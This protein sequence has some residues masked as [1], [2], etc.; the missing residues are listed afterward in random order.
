[1]VEDHNK[2]V[3]LGEVFDLMTAPTNFPLSRILFLQY[4]R[5]E[6]RYFRNISVQNGNICIFTLSNDVGI[7][8][9]ILEM[10]QEMWN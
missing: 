10:I 7:S 5:S 2:A 4:F 6:Q 3:G 1:M 9:F 8:S